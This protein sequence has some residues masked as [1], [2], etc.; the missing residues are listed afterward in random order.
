MAKVIVQ[1][2]Y[3]LKRD[4]MKQ[5]YE[6]IKKQLDDGLLV[7]DGSCRVVISKDTDIIAVEF[8]EKENDISNI[9]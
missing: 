4:A 2:P 1:Y 5:K 6:E 8:K 7:L 9:H 3:F